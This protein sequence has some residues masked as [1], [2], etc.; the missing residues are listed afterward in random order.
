MNFS[1]YK[2][3]RSLKLSGPCGERNKDNARDH[4]PG[5]H[6]CVVYVCTC[7]YRTIALSTKGTI[8]KY[9]QVTGMSELTFKIA[10]RQDKKNCLPIND[11]K[12]DAIYMYTIICT[13]TS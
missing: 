11:H 4:K 12:S 9:V 1:I 7:I 13:K 8:S 5:V 10:S 6:V 2:N 3:T